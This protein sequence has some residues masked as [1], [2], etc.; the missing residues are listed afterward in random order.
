MIL[1]RNYM[2]LDTLQHCKTFILWVSDLCVWVFES[3]I[4]FMA[5]LSIKTMNKSEVLHTISES[6]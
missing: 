5:P 2:Q 4:I 6:S 3:L 1:L